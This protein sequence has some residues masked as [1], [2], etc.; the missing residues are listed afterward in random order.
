MSEPAPELELEPEPKL[1]ES[2]SRSGKKKF[3]LHNTGLIPGQMVRRSG[4]KITYFRD[5][6]QLGK[7]N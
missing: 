6:I 4:R 1:F 3:R 7:G 2:R 5:W